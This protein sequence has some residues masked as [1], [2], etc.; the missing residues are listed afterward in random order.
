MEFFAG[1]VIG[2]PVSPN[3]EVML[4]A[5]GTLP[6]K[7]VQSDGVLISNILLVS[8]S[9]F[10][11]EELGLCIIIYRAKRPYPPGHMLQTSQDTRIAKL[12]RRVKSVALV[13]FLTIMG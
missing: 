11:V 13:D 12:P 9:R 4:Q 6:F 1:N 3:T 8:G 2:S 10:G 5:S 7:F